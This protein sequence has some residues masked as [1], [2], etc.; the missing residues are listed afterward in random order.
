MHRVELSQ[1][2]PINTPIYEVL[3]LPEEGL[4]QLKDILRYIKVG[5]S[6]WWKW[7]KEGIAPPPTRKIGAATFWRASDIRDFIA[8][9]D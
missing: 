5:R 8:K 2:K 7:V 3:S 1:E 4:L 6:T 9:D